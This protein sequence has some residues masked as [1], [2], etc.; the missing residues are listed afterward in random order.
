M[1]GWWGSARIDAWKQARRAVLPSESGAQLR[2]TATG[3]TYE[4]VEL[5]RAAL[6]RPL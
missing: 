3:D 6:L 5:R 1:N 2:A 4:F